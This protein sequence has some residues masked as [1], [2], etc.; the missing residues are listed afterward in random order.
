MQKFNSSFEGWVGD[1][2]LQGGTR[3]SG[4]RGNS[5]SGVYCLGDQLLRSKWAGGPPTSGAHLL[6]DSS[7]LILVTLIKCLPFYGGVEASLRM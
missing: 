2:L 7:S 5:Y 6:C 4:V 3:Y 1:H